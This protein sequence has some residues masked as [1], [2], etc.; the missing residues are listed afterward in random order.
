[1]SLHYGETITIPSPVDV[2]AHLREPGGED[3]ETIESGT[4]AACRGGY[5]LVCDMPNN[6]GGMETRSEE[7]VDEK[8]HIALRSAHTDL[9]I[10][11]GVNFDQPAFEEFPK[12]VRKVTGLK[13]YLGFTQGNTT[14][15]GLD[16]SRASFDEWIKQANLAGVRPPVM[17]HAREGVGEEVADYIA[18]QDYPVHWCHVST[19]TEID[20]VQRL[21][22]KF[23]DAGLFFSGVTLHHLTMTSIDANFK[24]GWP[25]GRMMPPLGDEV[26]HDALMHAYNNGEIPIL[27]TDHAPHASNNK[28]KAEIENPEGHNHPDCTTCFGISGIGQVIPIMTSL[29]MRGETTLERLV[30]SL[31]TQPLRMLGVHD[32]Q[33]AKTD[34]FIDPYQLHE[35]DFYGKSRNT[36]YLGWTAWGKVLDVRV[37]G[38]SRFD[39]K[40]LRSG[41]AAVR[42]VTTGKTI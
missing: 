21:N 8:A 7:R 31:R 19:K 40:T 9:G 29:I 22:K 42:V 16:E 34:I 11:C 13:G 10:N 1:M 33:S 39:E 28:T 3:K 36:P 38:I 41:R 30:D 18:S 26:D 24:Y 32:S 4:L 15:Y 6:P 27:E 12:M 35:D 17:L 5:Q 23:R 20:A 14:E 25:G 37:N 2:H